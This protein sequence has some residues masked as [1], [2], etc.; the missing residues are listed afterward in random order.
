MLRRLLCLITLAAVSLAT[1]SLTTVTAR[2]AAAAPSLMAGDADPAV[3]DL[4]AER[5]VGLAE[6]QRRIG[7]QRLA[8]RLAGD[9]A[10]LLGDRFG[11]VW[12]DPGSDRV[13]IG[14]IGGATE[15]ASRAARAVGLGD[16]T[17]PVTVRHSMSELERGNAWLAERI[18]AVN[19]GAA[20]ALTAGVRPDLN[21]IEL[22]LP[23]TGVLT[24]AQLALVDQ[25][26]RRL[27]NTLRL[28]RY[29]GRAVAR[30]CPYPY[31]DPPLRGGIRITN[32]GRGCTGAF[33]AR[34]RTD[35]TLYQFT[36]GHC[37]ADG[38]TGD[39]ATRFADGSGHVIGP[40]Y[41]HRFSSGGDLA[42]LRIN[43]PTGWNPRAWVFVTDSSD[44]NRDVSYHL[45]SDDTSTVGMRICTTGASYGRTDC[46]VV[47]ALGV[48]ATYNGIT[49]TGLNR[50]SFC[51]VSGDSGSP[52]YA[53]HV[54]YGL[55][56]AG[57]AECDSLYQGIQAAENAMNANL[58]HASS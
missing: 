22:Q 39:W 16:A 31:C 1:V 5:G 3:L 13:K 26:G 8:P 2:S 50:G 33:I 9:A 55:Q 53:Y 37:V 4:A 40:R 29:T 19:A 11:G 24:A 15:T 30:A 56:V 6:A 35:S 54:A 23:V 58:L 51:G 27:G 45:S 44:T 43:N 12:I 36:A 32:S 34:S 57:F 17:D 14:V 18:A 42:I 52:M 10:A 20:A 49:V 38:F 21:A 41:N 7:W 47:T 46:G 25:A 48:T 28:G